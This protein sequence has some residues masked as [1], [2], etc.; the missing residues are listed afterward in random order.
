MRPQQVRVLRVI[1]SH[2]MK[3]DRYSL[4]SNNAQSMMRNYGLSESAPWWAVK[5]NL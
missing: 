3:I 2:I 4:P 1:Y 5:H